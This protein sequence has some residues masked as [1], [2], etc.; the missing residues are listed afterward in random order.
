MVSLHI[1]SVIAAV[2]KAVDTGNPDF[3]YEKLSKP[4]ARLTVSI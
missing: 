2:T 1:L 3:V 4:D